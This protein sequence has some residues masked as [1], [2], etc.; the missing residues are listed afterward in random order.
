MN[1]EHEHLL[2]KNNGNACVVLYA[3]DDD[4]MMIMGHIAEAT[5]NSSIRLF[6][7]ILQ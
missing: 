5:H 2:E 4:F 6:T 3:N 1:N 7:S